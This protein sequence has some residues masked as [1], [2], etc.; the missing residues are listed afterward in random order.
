[1]WQNFPA[2]GLS[3]FFGHIRNMRAVVVLHQKNTVLSIRFFFL[4]SR[5]ELFHVL[6]IKFW[7]DC[8]VF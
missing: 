2:V 6:N 8:L 7:V 5:L 4:N 3:G 1:M